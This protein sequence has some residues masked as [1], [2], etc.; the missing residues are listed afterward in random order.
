MKTMSL[1]LDDSMFERVDHVAG[2]CHK[3]RLEIVRESIQARLE[4][5]TWLEGAIEEAR[6]D[7]KSGRYVS[8]DEAMKHMQTTKD[9]IKSRV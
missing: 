4:Y 5:E 7:F 1:K 2:R 6:E 9:R 3:S 8:H